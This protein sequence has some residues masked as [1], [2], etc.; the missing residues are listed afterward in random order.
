MVELVEG[1][2]GSISPMVA[3]ALV[4]GVGRNRQATAAANQITRGATRESEGGDW[5]WAGSV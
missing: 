4:T 1:A 2:E 3:T 5:G